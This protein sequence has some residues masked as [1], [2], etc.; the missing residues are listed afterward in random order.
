MRRV[1]LPK[2]NKSMGVILLSNFPFSQRRK[3]R[4]GKAG[5]VPNFTANALLYKNDSFTRR[6][7]VGMEQQVRALAVRLHL[8]PAKL[9]DSIRPVFLS[10]M[11]DQ[12]NGYIKGFPLS[13]L[14]SNIMLN[15]SSNSFTLK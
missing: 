12:K 3:G 10:T 9:D 8:W 14:K 4:K 11:T 7:A 15:P 5:S 13:N 2:V 6:V 1:R